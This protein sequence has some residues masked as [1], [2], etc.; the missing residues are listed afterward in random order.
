[1]A[2]DMVRLQAKALGMSPDS[3][4]AAVMGDEWQE[5]K[6][7]PEYD[8]DLPVEDRWADMERREQGLLP[9]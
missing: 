5:T 3:L 8:M 9:K 1:M 2:H 6:P 7:Q 4:I